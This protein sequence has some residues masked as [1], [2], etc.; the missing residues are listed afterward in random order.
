MPDGDIDAATRFEQIESR[1]VSLALIAAIAVSI[2]DNIWHFLD[3]Q[4]WAF[5]LVFLTLLIALRWMDVT[6]KRVV[7]IAAGTPLRTYDSSSAFYGEAL[8]AIA[9][10]SKT[11]HAVFSHTTPPPLQTAASRR[12]YNGTLTWARKSPGKRALLRVIR[13]RDSSPDVQGWVDEQ[14]AMAEKIENY[15][16]RILRYPPGMALEGENFVIVDSSVVFLGFAIDE[17][18]ELKGFSIRDARVGTAFEQYFSELW[19]ISSEGSAAASTNSSQAN[20][21]GSPSVS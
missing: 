13:L 3:N 14:T 19:H 17:R 21:P 15:H 6:R 2:A 10:S 18:G 16:L 4:N 20:V 5:P 7:A 1:A 12:Y 9:K 11:V 8:R